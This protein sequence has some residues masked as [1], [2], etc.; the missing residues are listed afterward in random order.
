MLHEFF[1]PLVVL[2]LRRRFHRRARHESLVDLA[3]ERVGRDVLVLR[4]DAQLL[5]G[6]RLE[7]GVLHLAGFVLQ[8]LVDPLEDGDA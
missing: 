4:K 6:Q 2:A 5:A 1:L 7:V 8:V 3:V